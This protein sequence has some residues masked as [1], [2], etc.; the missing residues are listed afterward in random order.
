MMSVQ[1]TLKWATSGVLALSLLACGGG[2]TGSDGGT[3][4]QDTLDTVVDQRSSGLMNVGGHLFSLPSP[5]QTALLFRKLDIGYQKDLPLVPEKAGEITGKVGRALALGMY[6]AD[7]AYVTVHRDGV[8]AISTLG[9]IEMLSGQLDLSN[10]FD[11]S[12]LERFKK[13]MGS[14]DSLL[15]LTGSVFRAADE[16]LKENGRNDVSAL[17]LAGGWIESL[18]LTIN[19]TSS[20]GDA[21]LAQ[22]IGE[23]KRTLDDL[24]KLLEESDQ[25]KL[26]GPLVAEL[27]VL[28]T[29]YAG[30]TSTYVFEKPVTDVAGKTTR[31]NSTT[32]VTVSPDQMRAIGAQ[33]MKMRSTILA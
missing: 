12:L 23:Q 29:A 26:C 32:T 11:R 5:V 28:Q 19:A 2:Q 4:G 17:V 31:I 18:Y 25:D 8:R 13:N 21:Q 33:V 10:A 6:G 1:D 27:K 3:P 7:L 9:T 30:V 15:V 14:E 22:R 20:K 16:Y 24:I